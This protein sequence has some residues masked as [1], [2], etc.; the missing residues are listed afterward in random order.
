LIRDEDAQPVVA[1]GVCYAGPMA[2]VELCHRAPSPPRLTLELQSQVDA[3][4]P[5]GCAMRSHFMPAI[6]DDAI[7][8]LID[9]LDR[10]SSPLSAVIIEHCHGTIER[11]DPEATAFALRRNPFHMEILAFWD[12]P[13]M[14]QSNLSW[15]ETFLV[16]TQPFGSGEVYVNS[17]DAGE[18]ARVPEAYGGNWQRLHALKAKYDPNNLFCCN[19]NIPPP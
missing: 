16:A 4:R 2:A 19:H 1:I 10:A 15:V 3:A 8:V 6:R 13:G 9:G 14:D 12:D 17:L 7:N 11:V 18:E 5:T